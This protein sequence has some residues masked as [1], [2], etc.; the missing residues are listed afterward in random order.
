MNPRHLLLVP[1]ALLVAPLLRADSAVEGRVALPKARSAPVMNKRYEVVTKA[2]ILSTNP[3]LA[4]VYLEGEF[5]PGP[6][7]PVLQVGQKDM[8][9]VPTLLPVRAGTRVE[10]PNYDDTYHNIFSYSPAKRFDLG[11]YRSDE[12][13]VPSVLFDQPGLVVLRCDIHEHMRGLI[14]V[15]AT[16]HFVVTD[17]DGNYRLAGLPPGR[18]VLKAWLDSRTTLE[19]AVDLRDGATLHADFP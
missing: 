9:F 18:Y 6:P 10:F 7:G 4:V 5:P 13:P 15:L 8:A 17:A 2:G 3:P 14:L 19:R 16:P 11:R 1:L 12:R